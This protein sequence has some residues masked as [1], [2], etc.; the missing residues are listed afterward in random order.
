MQLTCLAHLLILF[1]K[2]DRKSVSCRAVSRQQTA[3]PTQDQK[4]SNKKPHEEAIK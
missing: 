3:A 2:A 1:F 4:Q